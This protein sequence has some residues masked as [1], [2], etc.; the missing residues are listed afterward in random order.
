[1]NATQ[2]SFNDQVKQMTEMQAKSLEPM[3]IFGGLAADAIEQVVRQNYAVMG[4]FVEYTVKQAK[5]PVSGENAS[6]VMSAQMAEASAFGE[7]MST[8]ASEYAELATNLT[9]RARKAADDASASLKA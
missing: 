7:K 8:R 1:M 3:R 4:D 9:E 2:Q 6:D 5:L